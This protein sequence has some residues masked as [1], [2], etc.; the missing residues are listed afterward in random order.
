MQP[1][2]PDL[3]LKLGLSLLNDLRYLSLMSPTSCDK[4]DLLVFKDPFRGANIKKNVLRNWYCR[5][6]KVQLSIKRSQQSFI[7]A[8]LNLACLSN[9]GSYKMFF[10]TYSYKG[11]IKVKRNQYSIA[12][13]PGFWP[14]ICILTIRT[15]M[16]I[17]VSK[18]K[19]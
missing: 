7:P 9:R 10:L 4:P 14:A 8:I 18:F 12:L 5:T 19:L 15:Q 1:D 13:D 3:N 17:V 2:I 11:V 6:N 16:C